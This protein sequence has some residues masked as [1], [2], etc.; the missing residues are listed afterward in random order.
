[1]KALLC[2]ALLG[3]C[4]FDRP[5]DVKFGDSSIAITDGDHQTGVVA[6]DL[7]VALKVN[8]TDGDFLPIEN[9]TVE[10]S[11]RD[12]NGELSERAVRTDAQGN[13]RTELT[14]GTRSGDVFVDVTGEGIEGD[15]PVFFSAIGLPDVP[16]QISPFAGNGESVTVATQ[17]P[18][19]L[20]AR[21]ED[22]FGNASPAG[23]EVTFS[24]PSGTLSTTTGTSAAD[25]TVGVM[26]TLGTVAGPQ[27]VQAASPGLASAT[28]TLTGLAA[29]PVS[30]ER[31][32]PAALLAEA[33]RPSEPMVV[34]ARDMYGNPT[35]GATIMFSRTGGTGPAG[36]VATPTVTT[37][38]NGQAVGSVVAAALVGTNI[39]Q[40]SAAFTATTVSFTATTRNFTGLLPLAEVTNSLAN[41]LVVGDIN[42]DLLPDIVVLTQRSTPTSFKGFSVYLNTTPTGSATPTFTAATEIASNSIFTSATRLSLVDVT[43]DGRLDVAVSYSGLEVFPNTTVAGSA[44]PTFASAFN[45]SSPSRVNAFVADLDGDQMQDLV[46][47]NGS[48]FYVSRRTGASTFDNYQSVGSVTD[49]SLYFIDLDG[50]GKLDIT[51]FYSGSLYSYVNATAAGATTISFMPTS[52]ACNG[53]YGVFVDMD[54]DAK[55]DWV[56]AFIASARVFKNTTTTTPSFTGQPETTPGVYGPM[57]VFDVNGDGLPDIVGGNASNLRVLLNTSSG[58]TTSF[59]S[60]DL[61]ASLSSGTRVMTADFNKDGRMDLAIANAPPSIILAQ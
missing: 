22:R 23:V 60:S 51:S 16:A 3:A 33:L 1:M 14:L 41:T 12:A 8:V 27:T 34:T 46:T 26:Y 45:V 59:V 18:L 47:T 48:A 25:G 4:T 49:N 58:G 55:P 10:F 54:A 21:V 57:V 2:L 15:A 6:T 44:T 53:S 37:D 9:F 13:A 38:A 40:A 29:A 61:Q 17:A 5:A 56:C 7:P 28:F 19:P 52:I 36:T 42:N 32:S 30:I 39:V 31:T 50:D 24:A 11:V 43:G 35:P 20:V